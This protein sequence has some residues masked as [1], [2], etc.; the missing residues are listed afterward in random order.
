VLRDTNEVTS[1]T[2]PTGAATGITA[3]GDKIV[4]NCD[5]ALDLST[6]N[7]DAS[8]VVRYVAAE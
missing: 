6:T 3:D 7:L 2:F 1:C 5:T 8:L 4:L